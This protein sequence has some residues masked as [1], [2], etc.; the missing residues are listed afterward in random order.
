MYFKSELTQHTLHKLVHSFRSSPPSPRMKTHPPFRAQPHPFINNNL[1]GA[2]VP[3]HRMYVQ[4]I[5]S[6]AE[7]HQ[8][9]H[10]RQQ[11]GRLP[12]RRPAPIGATA[13][14]SAKQ[15][16][17]QLRRGPRS[18]LTHRVN[19]GITAGRR[20]SSALVTMPEM[21]GVPLGKRTIRTVLAVSRLGRR[22]SANQGSCQ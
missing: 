1:P 9:E 6:S 3:K 15:Q 20:H 17:Y 18:A 22:S 19:A 13:R 14:H 21:P 16:L 11:M 12:H 8:V 5:P 7:T 2:T 10:C 4:G